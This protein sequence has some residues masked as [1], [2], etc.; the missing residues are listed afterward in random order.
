MVKVRGT[1]VPIG[2][3]K[4]GKG[5]YV[6]RAQFSEAFTFV[7]SSTSSLEQPESVSVHN[8]LHNAFVEAVMGEVGFFF[9][10]MRIMVYGNQEKKE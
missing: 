3:Q 7:I 8:M 2:E 5:Q 6:I 1:G 4:A 9:L 10:G